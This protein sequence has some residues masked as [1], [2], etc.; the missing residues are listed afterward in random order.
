MARLPEGVEGIAKL[1]ELVAKHGGG[2]LDP[3]EVVVG[4]ETDRNSWGCKP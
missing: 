1:H 4:I 2:A 3:A